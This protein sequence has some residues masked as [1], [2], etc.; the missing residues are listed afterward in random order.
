[1]LGI[2]CNFIARVGSVLDTVERG[3]KPR[4]NMRV[5][6]RMPKSKKDQAEYPTQWVTLSIRDF[7]ADYARNIQ[8][9]QQVSVNGTLRTSVSEDGTKTWIDVDVDEITAF[10][11]GE[12]KQDEPSW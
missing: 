4:H 9:G 8:V 7:N 11:R 6:I 5:A 3:G 2:K 1:M 12:A 10:P